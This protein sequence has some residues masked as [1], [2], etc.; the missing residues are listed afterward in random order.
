MRGKKLAF[1]FTDKRPAEY[2]YQLQNGLF[3]SFNHLTKNF[4]VMVVAY[5]DQ[6]NVI[7]RSN[8][9]I[10]LR[11]TDKSM[12]FTIREYFDPTHAFFVG[13]PDF[14]FDKLDIPDKTPKFYI[15]KGV[16]H[17]EKYFDYFDNV[18]VET[19][20]EKKHYK[21]SVVAAVTNTKMYFPQ[22]TDKYFT[23]CFP[24]DLSESK[25][26]FFSKVRVYGSISQ[27]LNSTVRLP[28]DGTET[29]NTVINQSK[30]VSLIE[31]TN[32]SFEIAL[33]ALACN[34]PVLATTDSKA[35]KI[36]PV[37]KSLATTPD[38]TVAMLEAL[39]LEKKYNFREEYILPNYSP[40]M[41]AKT[42][43]DLI[44]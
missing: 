40:K 21:N 31:D 8:Y 17:S 20:E 12:A 24:Q 37:V 25:L 18:I 11:N 19:E 7:R 44:L 35:S 29:L 26:D 34:V 1:I 16:K 4:E 22:E 10:M 39:N 30:A 5:S 32:E 2:Y 33:S 23:F 41:Y 15:H 13:T 43:M 3:E 38:F 42:I 6:L 27:T 9:D 14:N 36:P 28:L